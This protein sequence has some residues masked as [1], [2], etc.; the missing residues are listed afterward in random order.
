MEQNTLNGLILAALLAY[1][2]P[3]LSPLIDKCLKQLLG[4]LL[5]TVLK[6]LKG[7]F[8]KK[9]LISLKEFRKMRANHSAVTM[10]I[11]RAHA[12]FILFWGVIAFYINLLTQ[13]AF[14][15]VLDKNFAFGMLLTSPIYVFQLFW[16]SADS[17]AKKLVKNRG[18]LGL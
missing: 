17:K 13:P 7:Y 1:I 2:I 18:K 15:A 16:L 3:K 11:V 5:K 9:R 8:R 6:P 12:Y 14:P 10:Q 4:F